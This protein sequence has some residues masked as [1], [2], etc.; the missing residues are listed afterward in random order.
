M[1]PHTQGGCPAKIFDERRP[2]ES[3]NADILDYRIRNFR[4]ITKGEFDK[5]IDGYLEVADNLD[6]KIDWN[7]SETED[8]VHQ[9]KLA[10][11]LKKVGLKHWVIN[12]QGAYRQTDPNAVIAIIPK[13]LSEE[14]IPDYTKPIPNFNN[15]VNQKI[16]VDVRLVTHDNIVYVDTD[17]LLFKVGSWK[18]GEKDH[19]SQPYFFGLT[20]DKTFLIYPVKDE[21]DKDKFVYKEIT[22]YDNKLT[23]CP[24][25]AI[26]GA[27]ITVVDKE[28]NTFEYYISDY[29]GA[30][31]WGDL[32]IGQGS[33]LQISEVR[34]TYPRHWKIKITCDNSM[35]EYHARTGRHEVFHEGQHI[36]CARCAGTG[37]IQDDSP[38]GTLLIAK[39]GPLFGE[40]GKFQVPE[41]FVTPDTTIL[42]HSADRHEAYLERMRTDLNIMSQ[43]MTNQ[44]A[45]RASYDVQYKV[46]TNT[47]IVTGLYSIYLNVVN[48]ID[49]YRGGNGEIT[50][51]FPE[52]FDV[53][54]AT[55]ILT[56]ISE[57]RNNKLP[58]MVIV[59]LTKKYMLKKFGKSPVNNF[60]VDFLSLYDTLFAYS[61]DDMSTIKGVFGS[62][63]SPEQLAIHANGYQILR[64]MA[65]NED[66]FMKR[67]F[68]DIKTEL[69]TE[70]EK[71]IVQ[72]QTL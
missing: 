56:E 22:Y 60:I 54:N 50:I 67:S 5:A 37:F 64:K 23:T 70:I 28:G 44:S 63:I 40:D 25:V 65:Q 1:E 45:E 3:Q 53:Q 35:G 57:A 16:D 18:Y 31:A 19:E 66:A 41:G 43:N 49:E 17:S 13:H 62:D 34:F 48:I 7:G 42:K 11:G 59:E 46:S 21:K 20:K 52:D 33:D 26:G 51:T 71:F 38:A 68:E 47:R 4:A 69:D 8:F 2:L 61:L 58:Y 6:V 55:D 15:I 24:V 36:A 29:F 30:T 39:G 72:T 12:K 14:L 32:A 27:I 9:Y 10:D